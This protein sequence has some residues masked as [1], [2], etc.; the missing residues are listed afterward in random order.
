MKKFRIV[1]MIILVFALLV[2][3]LVACGD[4][5]ITDAYVVRVNNFK[6][7]GD[8][9]VDEKT[10]TIKGN[11][12]N[13]ITSFDIGNICFDKGVTFKVYKDKLCQEEY[14]GDVITI[15]D[16]ENLVYL[17]I[18]CTI[19]GKTLSPTVWTLS[20]TKLSSLTI[21]S[22]EVTSFQTEYNVGDA[23][24]PGELKVKYSD[25]K[26][27]NAAITR[28]M[29][30]GFETATAG[31]KNVTI[32][33]AGKTYER[34]ILVKKPNVDIQVEAI[35]VISWDYNYQ[36]GEAFKGG[37]LR[38]TYSDTSIMDVDI[39]SDM[40]TG[41]TTAAAGKVSVTIKYAGKSITKDIIV[42]GAIQPSNIEYAEITEFLVKC[43]TYVMSIEG[44]DIDDKIWVEYYAFEMSNLM[45]DIPADK[46]Q[47]IVDTCRRA[48]ISGEN[49]NNLYGYLSNFGLTEIV[50]WFAEGNGWEEF[51]AIPT[52]K[53]Y[54]LFDHLRGTAQGIY[55]EFTATQL[56]V[57]LDIA[58][59]MVFDLLKQSDMTL[60]VTREEAL[61][62]AKTETDKKLVAEFYDKYAT[63]DFYD[64][65]NDLYNT[66]DKTKVVR[67]II[68]IVD[69]IFQ[70]PNDDINTILLTVDLF[71][72]GDGNF[73]AIISSNVALKKI[74]ESVKI[75]GDNLLSLYNKLDFT[76]LDDIKDVAFQIFDYFAD[77]DGELEQIK[78]IADIAVEVLPAYIHFAA[79]LMRGFNTDTISP[80]ALDIQAYMAADTE[81]AKAEELGYA[82]IRISNL[83][84]NAYNKL[85][86][87]EQ[88][89]IEKNS[90]DLLN[91]IFEVAYLKQ[92]INAFDVLDIIDTIKEFGKVDVKTITKLQAIEYGNRVM[93]LL[94]GEIE[95]KPFIDSFLY[96]SLKVNGEWAAEQIVEY[97]NEN[98]QFKV[99]Y[100]DTD[101]NEMVRVPFV[102]DANSLTWDAAARGNVE[103]TITYTDGNITAS[104]TFKVYVYDDAT[105]DKFILLPDSDV[106][107]KR[108]FYVGEE[109]DFEN[110]D[111]YDH[112]WEQKLNY[113]LWFSNADGVN[114]QIGHHS[115]EEFAVSLVG[116][117]TG[118]VGDYVAFLKVQHDILGE[119]MVP[120]RYS[121]MTTREA[122][123]NASLY[124][125][126]TSAFYFAEQGGKLD[127]HTLKLYVGLNDR[128]HFES[129]IKTITITS[130][131]V[132]N[133]D[134]S[135]LGFQKVLIQYEDTFEETGKVSLQTWID[136]Y[137][138]TKE[139]GEYMRRVS[140]SDN[141]DNNWSSD[142]DTNWCIVGGNLDNM[143]ISF[144][145]EYVD[146]RKNI[147]SYDE[148]TQKD[149]MTFA[150]LNAKLRQYNMQLKI[151]GFSSSAQK[152]NA[153]ATFEL[154]QSGKCIY[155]KEFT[156]N[157]YDLNKEYVCGIESN[158]LDLD[159]VTESE[160]QDPQKIWD[161]IV[162]NIGEGS[163]DVE[164]V[165]YGMLDNKIYP[166]TRTKT[167][168][169]AEFSKL[170][171]DKNAKIW[172]EED[173]DGYTM[174]ISV[175]GY[176]RYYSDISVITDEDAKKITD[177]YLRA[178]ENIIIVQ[179]EEIPKDKF[180]LQI[181]YGYGYRDVYLSFAEAGIYLTGN[182]DPNTV[183]EYNVTINLMNNEVRNVT[184]KVI[185]Q[186][187]AETITYI[188]ME[189]F[190]K[191]VNIKTE[192][193]VGEEFELRGD[194]RVEY[195]YGYYDTWK[196]FEYNEYDKNVTISGFDSAKVGTQTVTI[197]FSKYVS[198]KVDV[199][200]REA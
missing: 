138:G 189:E 104:K 33:Y 180:S 140:L 179:G 166:M 6:G 133:F 106:H 45:S 49:L 93:E 127:G 155:T 67:S 101:A 120:V 77:A 126:S 132:K 84:M 5:P 9:V 16:G 94:T 69:T 195:G 37:K 81:D 27:V 134:S 110:N 10:Q 65:M 12:S 20:I 74:I 168:T 28:N 135:N 131:M 97:I 22:V 87:S 193:V 90:N 200:V 185:S 31:V 151:K 96:E 53:K 194:C 76:L 198:V 118:K 42:E 122:L 88:A 35:D 117:D 60:P 136:V 175:D 190:F 115:N 153:P 169:A 95:R 149:R 177:V 112:D 71:V 85:S 78:G 32:T 186:E 170:L 191:S 99:C 161:R 142:S 183:G 43:T 146:A 164:F 80:I 162:G 19:E 174:H 86:V 116:L 57:A 165:T 14:K 75:A 108:A 159:S 1:I 4:D 62:A 40:L 160:L 89:A 15:A 58:P 91:A 63:N 18:E 148:T 178:E 23:F 26:E 156:Y 30:T 144:S 46:Q 66:L 187:D 154:Y 145:M 83:F 157:V 141:S 82:S 72:T 167:L 114:I 11:V 44:N 139:Q 171:E 197:T 130:D 21:T 68:S 123:Y 51:M 124:L 17:K 79:E 147:N 52:E 172:F 59:G 143:M 7:I 70:I 61:D 73:D 137:V 13:E 41:F 47:M 36:I 184:I 39:T 34:Q 182:Y 129:Y 158:Y 173:W 107:F 150:N 199:V 125:D 181:S 55:T 29:V 105:E 56:A 50:D 24:V 100:Y 111:S 64:A 196:Y 102:A 163:I 109:F 113:W 192:Y 188:D 119:V 25:G 152:F 176:K 2:P 3:G 48:G 128:W 8:V 103:F 54:R 92:Y 98:L 121:V 38:V